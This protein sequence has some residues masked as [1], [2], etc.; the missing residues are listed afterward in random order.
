[1]QKQ[2]KAAQFTLLTLFVCLLTA[3]VVIPAKALET[4]QDQPIQIT[5]ISTDNAEAAYVFI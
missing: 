3:T 4:W 5:D 2:T 1:M